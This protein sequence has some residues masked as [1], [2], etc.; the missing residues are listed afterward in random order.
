[1]KTI[2]EELLD[3]GTHHRAYVRTY[4]NGDPYIESYDNTIQS[5]I[6]ARW[7][8][9]TGVFCVDLCMCGGGDELWV[10]PDRRAFETHHSKKYAIRRA[11][12]IADEWRIEVALVIPPA[13][14]DDQVMAEYEAR[15]QAADTALT[16]EY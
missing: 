1:M 2:F 10:L 16:V 4:H 8:K 3:A 11:I 6:I 15:K 7:D 14:S 9:A 12:E 13:K 5:S